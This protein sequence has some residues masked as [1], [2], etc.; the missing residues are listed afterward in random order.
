MTP[1]SDTSDVSRR[2]QLLETVQGVRAELVVTGPRYENPDADFA[3]VALPASDCD[4][5]RDLVIRERAGVVIEIGLAYGS[6]ALAIGEALL[7]Q[8]VNDPKHLIVDP[9]QDHFHHVGWNA[10]ERAGLTDGAEL[11]PERSQVALP[12]L[13]AQGFT[14]DVGFVDGSHLFHNVFVD[15][16]FLRELVRPN[17]LIILDDCDWPSVGTA[18]SYFE[19]NCGWQ[20]QAPTQSSRLRSFRLPDHVVEPEA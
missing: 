5:L 13:L 7:S 2:H 9:Y 10:I 8:D 12:R 6:S 15:L 4:A 11:V 18:V 20:S 3:R 16:Y 1:L 17:G 19:L 14:A